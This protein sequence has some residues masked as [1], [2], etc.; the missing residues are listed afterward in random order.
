[1]NIKFCLLASLIFQTTVFAQNDKFEVNSVYVVDMQ[2]V[3]EESK[4]G[5]K[6]VAALKEKFQESQKIAEKVTSELNTLR[7]SLEKQASLLS[8]EVFQQK[9]EA[10]VLKKRE[11]ENLLQE[12]KVKTEQF[13]A[14]EISNIVEQANKIIN[15]ISQ[16]KNYQLVVEKSSQI[17]IYADKQLDITSDVISKMGG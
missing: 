14:R 4:Q 13:R 16:K 12:E 17:V 8:D 1:M 6:T 7:V 15:E 3:L 2:K 9:Q 5:K 11:S 10:L